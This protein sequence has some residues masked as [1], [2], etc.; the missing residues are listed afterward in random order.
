MTDDRV[1]DPDGTA[2]DAA[3]A[4]AHAVREARDADRREG[5][6]LGSEP[7]T[8]GID[9]PAN[10]QGHPPKN[11]L[12]GMYKALRPKQWVKNVL[13]IA[14]PAAAG[15]E[16]L[17]DTRTLIDVLIA[18]AVFCLAASSIYLVNDARD[19]EADRA[20]PTKRFRPIAAGVLP[21]P[22]AYAMAVIL[23][24][25]SIGLSFLASSGPGL[26]IV[27]SVYIALQLGYCFG[28]KHQPVIDIALVSSGFMLRAM[29]GGVA[30]SILLSQ[31]FLLVA[32]F[33]SLFMAAGK[34]YAELLLAQ[35][36]QKKIRKSLEGYTATYLRFVWTL[37]ATA[38][39]LAYSLWGFEMGNRAGGAAAVWY[40]I[41]MVPFTVA[42]LRYAADVDRGTA[43]SPDE[44][45]LHDRALQAL[46]LLWII[47]IGIAV[48]AVPA[49]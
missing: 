8:Y 19:V 17:T 2:R 27:V 4:A 33:G 20:H 49:L 35:R 10:P 13:V 23:I 46:A 45:A 14:A 25:A 37:S 9:E 7:H 28:W 29:A 36:S 42:I 30:A 5:L 18:F 6:N 32:A 44:I 11:L 41:S 21:V 39:V 26:A 16:A 3:P 48:Y 47:S 38:V 34:R 24:A 1:K 22:L 43:G 15:A 12:D 31:W 40:Q